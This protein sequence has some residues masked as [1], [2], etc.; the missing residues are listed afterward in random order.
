MSVLAIGFVACDEYDEAIP[1]ANEQKPIV[2]VKG[3]EVAAAEA[4]ANPIDLNSTTAPIE[5]IKTVK[6]PVLNENNSITYD[7]QIASDEK[8]TRMKQ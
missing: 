7:V 2:E 6:T 5:L 1:Q 8:F 4:M 3:L